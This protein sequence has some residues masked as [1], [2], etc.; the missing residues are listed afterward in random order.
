M[1]R[2]LASRLAAKLAMVQRGYSASTKILWANFFPCLLNVLR[3]VPWY[4]L[5]GTPEPSL[6]ALSF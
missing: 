5:F 3:K 1:F 4:Y 6:L 2:V